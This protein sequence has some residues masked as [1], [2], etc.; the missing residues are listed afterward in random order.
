MHVNQWAERTGSPKSPAGLTVAS[1]WFSG[2]R[3]RIEC[4]EAFPASAWRVS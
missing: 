1:G 3:R 4:D 2:I